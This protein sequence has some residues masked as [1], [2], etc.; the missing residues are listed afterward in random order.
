MSKPLRCC[1]LPSSFRITYD[2]GS[3]S[4]QIIEICSNH[5]ENEKAFQLFVISKEEI[6][7]K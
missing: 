3:D 7:L 2:C 5:Y 1:N 6:N 4:T